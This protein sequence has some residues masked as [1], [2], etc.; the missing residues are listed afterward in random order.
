M[1]IRTLMQSFQTAATQS[2]LSVDFCSNMKL[3][4][5]RMVSL[6]AGAVCTLQVGGYGKRSVEENK[7]IQVKPMSGHHQ[8]G[9]VTLK[10]SL[11]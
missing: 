5:N 6:V 10:Q 4:G 8:K 1:P 2:Y 9:P 7:D 11:E 3:I